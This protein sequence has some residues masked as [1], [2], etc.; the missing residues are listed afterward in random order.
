MFRVAI[1]TSGLY[2]TQAGVSRYIRGLIKG[3]RKLNVSELQLSEVAWAV[4]N[5]SFQQPQRALKTLFRELVW[6]KLI[7]PRIERDTPA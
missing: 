3:I 1:D 6:A 4:E 2:T 5:F 7:A